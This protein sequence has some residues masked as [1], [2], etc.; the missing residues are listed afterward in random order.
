MNSDPLFFLETNSFSF[1]LFVV[2]WFAIVCSTL[3]NT[4]LHISINQ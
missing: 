4:Y 1:D 3:T 2:F